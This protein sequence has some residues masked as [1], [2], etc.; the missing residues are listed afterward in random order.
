I[1]LSSSPW[2]CAPVFALGWMVTVPAHS[3]CAPARAESMAAARDIPGV[4][5]VF[6]SSSFAWTMRTPCSRQSVMTP[7]V[8]VVLRRTGERNESD[9]HQGALL[10]AAGGSAAPQLQLLLLGR[11][12]HRQHHAASGRELCEQRRRHLGRGGR[13]EDGVERRRL[14]PAER[15]VSDADL[16]V[17]VSQL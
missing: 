16:D 7:S 10:E 3:F 5:A 17:L 13:D 2:W 9:L 11:P 1:T 14:G 6:G 4:C 12:P 15:S 8:Q